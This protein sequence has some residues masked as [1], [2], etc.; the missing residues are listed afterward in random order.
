MKSSNLNPQT[1]KSDK[2]E[3]R[4]NKII[5]L[6]MSLLRSLWLLSV[7]KTTLLAIVDIAFF[8][9][10]FISFLLHH[11]RILELWTFKDTQPTD[12]FSLL[13]SLFLSSRNLFKSLAYILKRNKNISKG[14]WHKNCLTCAMT[15]SF[16]WLIDSSEC[17]SSI[18]FSGVDLLLNE[19]GDFRKNATLNVMF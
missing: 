18:M 15:W 16:V 11:K 5:K 1:Q 14:E 6:F 12:L 2:S 9:F 8:L 4:E 10:R 17:F 13:T 19:G 7:K 3:E